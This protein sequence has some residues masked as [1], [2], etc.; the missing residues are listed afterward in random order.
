MAIGLRVEGF[1]V[2]T[3][4]SSAE[5][6]E[7][8]AAQPFDLA[9]VDLMMPGTNGIQLARLVARATPGYPRRPDERL[10]PERAAAHPGRLRSGG[11]RSQATRLGRARAVSPEQSGVRRVGRI[12][13]ARR[14]PGRRATA[15]GC[16][17]RGAAVMPPA[18]ARRRLPLRAS[19]PSSSRSV[20]P[21]IGSRRAFCTCL[22]A[23]PLAEHRRV[24]ELP[25][26]LPRGALVVR[27]RH[28]GHPRP[29][30]RPQARHRG[31]RRSLP[32][33]A[34]RTC[35]RSRPGR[36]RREPRRS[37]APSGRRASRSGSV[38]TSRSRV[39]RR[40]IRG[41]RTA[42]VPLRPPAR[43]LGRG[44]RSARG[45]ALDAVGEPGR[46]RRCARAATFRCPRTS[47]A[48]TTLEDAERYQTVY[49]RHD[50]AVAAPTA[51]L[52]L[53]RALLGRLAVR[54]CEIASVT[55]HV[56]LGTFQPVQVDDLD[57]HPMHSERYVVT[58]ATADA[59]ARARA[60]G[61]PVV[62]VG[63]TTVRA[64]ESAAD[65]AAP[66][67]GSARRPARR[68]YSSSPATPG[69]S[70]TDCSPTS[71]CRARRCSRSSARSA[72]PSACSTRT[73][74]PW[75]S[76]TGSSRTATRC[77]S[78]EAVDPAD[79][80]LRV[81]RRRAR[82]TRAPRGVRRRRTARRD[83]DVHARR[84]A[85]QRQD[86][87]A[88][89]RSTSTGARMVLGNTYHLMLRPGADAIA[90]LGGLHAFT[91]WP[92]AMLT[93]SGGF[94][95]YSL[96]TAAGMRS[97]VASAEE[98]FAFKSHLDGSKH[99][100]TPEEA[101]RVQG[102]LGADIQ[103]QLD[104]CPPGDSPRAVVEEAVARTTRWAQARARRAHGRHGRRSS[105]SSRAPASPIFAALTPT[106][107]GLCPSTAS[108]SAASRSA[109]QSSGCTRRSSEVASALD[110][111]R[112]RYLMGVGTPRDLV[113]AIG[114]GVD[115]FDCVLPT[116]NAR[117]GQALTRA[118][119]IVIKQARYK[120]DPR[121]I[122]EECACAC[123]AERLLARLPPPSLPG[124]RDPLLAASLAPQFA[125]VRRARGGRSRGDR[126][127]ALRGLVKRAARAPAERRQRPRP[128]PRHLNRNGYRQGPALCPI[129]RA[130]TVRRVGIP[131]PPATRSDRSAR[132]CSSASWC[133]SRSSIRRSARRSDRAPRHLSRRSSWTTARSDEVDALRALSEQH[134]VPG[135]DLTQIAIVLEHLDVV[136]R[137]VAET[138][139]DLAGAR[140][141]RP[142][143]PG[144]GG[145]AR[146][147]RGR[148]ARVRHWQEGLPVH[149]GALD[150]HQGDRRRVRRQGAG[151]SP[152]PWPPGA[153]GHSA[154]A[155][156]ARARR[157]AS[158][159]RRTAAVAPAARPRAR[160]GIRRGRR[161]LGGI[162]ERVRRHR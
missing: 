138:Q 20:R 29:T 2:E 75:P 50:G 159:R 143:L 103:M 69:A 128:G 92:H 90:E 155:G 150:A 30:G 131:C 61:A 12:R 153:A 156:F 77:C 43:T 85:G 94:Q 56:G 154:P 48:T 141:R 41:E 52:H 105:G 70:S 6:L 120:D 23:G 68:G 45:R 133:R 145:P 148:R 7:R 74:S 37:G 135:I 117:N 60:R 67:H 27:Q 1:D 47:S 114:A 79:S 140:A 98:G 136:P 99:T 137:E 15:V 8:L 32:S 161:D 4:D 62:A 139:P 54:G 101:V 73:V 31:P 21:R 18:L 59:V 35:A 124:G 5:A 26:L 144:D 88:R 22:E 33:P 71:T 89:A 17:R 112:P 123:C 102:L 104:V 129:R 51:G 76:A 118:G 119:R 132:S 78:G 152:L 106:S 53:T 81:P 162:D 3:A 130:R 108:R 64:L 111:E 134:G 46:R 96:S 80:R 55:L 38:P 121:P 160:S 25:D 113:L 147:A 40:P 115:M 149:R 93:D 28:A 58:P 24:S 87:R 110:A 11:I 95:A 116:R 42:A 125:L 122:D 84:H 72:V 9:I 49:A 10:P 142:D 66:R 83:P 19:S 57:D 36:R 151:R 13:R 39:A 100:L 44:R 158:G 146:Q 109:S 34:R 126:L 63:T 82:R 107:S 97:L 91:R 14:R 127:V 86:A 16:G 65:P 157:G